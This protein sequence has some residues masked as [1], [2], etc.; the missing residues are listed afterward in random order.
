MIRPRR[1]RT[2]LLTIVAACGL[3]ALLALAWDWN[4]LRGP[5]ARHVAERAGRSIEIGHLDIRFDGLDPTVQ[6]T[7]VSVANAPWVRGTAGR[8][9]L[10]AQRVTATI[11]WRSL[12]ADLTVVTKL[13]LSGAD[14][15]LERQ[16]DGLRNWRLLEPDDRGPPRARILRLEAHRSTLHFIHEGLALDLRVSADDLPA[17]VPRA[18]DAPLTSRLRFQGR[19]REAAFSADAQASRVLTFFDTGEAFSV[20]GTAASGALR[21]EIDGLVGDLFALGRVDADL[22]LAGPS[23][24]DLRPLLPQAWPR[25][26]AFT[27]AARLQKTD[28]HWRLGGLRATA[29]RSDATGELA[30]TEAA[31]RGRVD[32]KL[33]SEALHLADLW[34]SG[35]AASG[36]QGLRA[37]D[38]QASWDIGTL[39]LPVLP[40]LSGVR[41]AA[42][43]TDG[44][45]E[46]S[47]A[48]AR[49]A[50]GTVQGVLSI[51]TRQ[52]PPAAAADLSW[53][54]LRIE[55]LL[56]A[57]PAKSQVSGPVSGQLQAAGRGSSWREVLA[58]LQGQAQVQMTSGLLA[59]YLDARLALN[60]DKLLRAALTDPG[61][62]PV[63]CARADLRLRGGT[64]EIRPLVIDT[65]QTRVD[66]R[67]T[68]DLRRLRFTLLLTPQP[69]EAALLALERSLRITGSFD[70]A[71]VELVPAEA[72]ARSPCN[73][74][75]PAPGR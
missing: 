5:V 26:A 15:H 52:Q 49:L 46:I 2:V 62:V 1:R 7:Q 35:S 60:G 65:A 42:R 22:R 74:G 16:A 9:L 71:E 47:P 34:R 50:G 8:P 57:L 64:G 29:G 24:A 36:G 51:D 40:P 25:T 63:R 21:L 32:A 30:Y 48:S 68:V 33:A 75:A 17:P 61:K 28:A 69:K 10:V 11:A 58:A 54:G 55:Q 38:V 72:I 31:G 18:Q 66:G 20:R 53:R 13:V 67:G 4:W 56:P 70:N 44:A 23:L 19:F 27:A 73:P 43:L 41:T 3:L 14:L 37:V 59:P 6:L 12:F 45:L 39:H